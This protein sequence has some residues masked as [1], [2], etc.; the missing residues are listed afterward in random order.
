MARASLLACEPSTH[1][2]PGAQK[3]ATPGLILIS[4][5]AIL[6]LLTIFL[7]QGSTFSFCTRSHKLGL[8]SCVYLKYYSLTVNVMFWLHLL[9][10]K[11]Y[12]WAQIFPALVSNKLNTKSCLYLLLYSF[13]SRTPPSQSFSG[14]P[15]PPLSLGSKSAQLRC[16]P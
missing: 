15:G 10:P 9:E 14:Y 1:T 8:Q 5:V 11:P 6:K 16:T 13:I 2:G 3:G 7:T 12:V 4:P